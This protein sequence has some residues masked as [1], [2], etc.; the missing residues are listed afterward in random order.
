MWLSFVESAGFQRTVLSE[1]LLVPLVRVIIVNSCIR[2]NSSIC[3]YTVGMGNSSCNS[4]N[5]RDNHKNSGSD[6]N[7]QRTSDVHLLQNRTSEP[8]AAYL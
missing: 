4:G 7:H 6:G 5:S 2:S 1:G 3:S 8:R